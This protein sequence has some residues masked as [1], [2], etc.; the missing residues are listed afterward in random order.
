[1][2]VHRLYRLTCDGCGTRGEIAH[3]N[4]EARKVANANGI[5]RVRLA[6]VT[7][8]GEQPGPYRRVEAINRDFCEK[9]RSNGQVAR[10]KAAILANRAKFDY[11]PID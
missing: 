6:R 9:C 1:M 7:L 2:A 3:E 5:R 10:T 4:A 11:L 8:K